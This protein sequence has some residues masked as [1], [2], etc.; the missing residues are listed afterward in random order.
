MPTPTPIAYTLTPGAFA[1]RVAWIAALNRTALRSH[2]QERGT[3]SLIYAPHAAGQ[4]SELVRRERACCPFLRFTLDEGA[5]AVR[6][7]VEAP[8]EVRGTGSDTAAPL[9]A[10]FLAGVPPHGSG[11]APTERG[12]P[13]HTGALDCATRDAADGDEHWTTDHAHLSAAL[14][15]RPPHGHP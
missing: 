10:P 4:V 3:L 11:G 2:H 1:E 6:L 7:T 8:A 5:D 12:A 15:P 13:S 14:R 9:F